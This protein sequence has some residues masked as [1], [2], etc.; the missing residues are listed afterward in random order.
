MTTSVAQEYQLQEL[1][2][3]T[4]KQL[5][6]TCVRLESRREMMQILLEELHNERAKLQRHQ[7]MVSD[8]ITKVEGPAGSANVAR[9]IQNFKVRATSQVATSTEVHAEMLGGPGNLQDTKHCGLFDAPA[10][11]VA[12]GTSSG[13]AA[14]RGRSPDCSVPNAVIS[15]IDTT[16]DSVNGMPL[17]SEVP[18]GLGFHV[19]AP[20]ELLARQAPSGVVTLT[21]FYNEEL[22][23]RFADPHDAIRNLTFEIRQL[24]EGANGRLRSRNHVCPCRGLAEGQEVGEQSF[25]VEGLAFGRPY[26]FTVRACLKVDGYVAPIYSAPSETIAVGSV[27]FQNLDIATATCTPR[28]AVHMA[29]VASGVGA[30]SASQWSSADAHLRPEDEDAHRREQKARQQQ[31]STWRRREVQED[32]TMHDSG[33][34]EKMLEEEVLRRL[35]EERRRIT[36]EAQRAAENERWRLEEELKQRRQ[37]EQ[38][39]IREHEE[40]RQRFVDEMRSMEYESRRQLEEEA[41]QSIRNQ[42]R[43]L[44]EEEAR[45]HAADIARREE[46]LARHR[47]AEALRRLAEEARER[48]AEAKRR[49]DNEYATQRQS[50]EQMRQEEEQMRQEEEAL[51]KRVEDQIRKRVDVEARR[52]DNE[53]ARRREEEQ[54]Q[55]QDEE[56]DQEEHG[57]QCQDGQNSDQATISLGSPAGPSRVTSS[58][59]GR[60]RG[61]GLNARRGTAGDAATS[62]AQGFTQYCK[63]KAAG[64]TGPQSGTRKTVPPQ[65]K[66][67]APYH[68]PSAASSLTGSRKA[69]ATGTPGSSGETRSTPGRDTAV[70]TQNGAQVV[71]VEVTVQ[72]GSADP[73]DKWMSK[74]LTEKNMPP[75]T[76]APNPIEAQRTPPAS[77]GTAQPQPKERSEAAPRVKTRASMPGTIPHP[78]ED[79]E[80]LSRSPQPSAARH[81]GKSGGV[82][83]R[84]SHAPSRSPDGMAT[85]MQ[86]PKR[87]SPAVAADRG[88]QPELRPPPQAEP[89]RVQSL[90]PTIGEST[91][92]VNACQIAD[93]AGMNIGDS[94]RHLGKDLIGGSMRFQ[95]SGA[96]DGSIMP[97][98]M[99]I[100]R[101]QTFATGKTG[102]GVVPC[103]TTTLT[104][105]LGGGVQ[106]RSSSFSTYPSV[107]GSK[108]PSPCVG[109]GS[110]AVRR[111]SPMR[112]SQG[113]GALQQQ[114]RQPVQ[115]RPP[116]GPQPQQQGFN[117]ASTDS[118]KSPCVAAPSARQSQ[119]PSRVPSQQGPPLAAVQPPQQ[120]FNQVGLT[121][122]NLEISQRLARANDLQQRLVNNAPQPAFAAKMPPGITME[123][124]NLLDWYKEQ[125]NRARSLDEPRAPTID[126]PHG[127]FG[128]QTLHN[129]PP[130]PRSAP[131]AEEAAACFGRIH[132][133]D[134]APDR[135]SLSFT[136]TVLTSDSRWENLIFSATENLEAVG[137]TFLQ[138][139]G[140]KT[141]FRAGLVSKM[142]S[143]ITSGQ[144]NSSVD[145]VDLI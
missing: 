49:L 30:T 123:M 98:N 55:P 9:L 20:E 99:Q 38:K 129:L 133:V 41:L 114:A 50:E 14:L 13:G 138:E 1:S 94:T 64:S 72:S 45:R 96:Q 106:A 137:T 32:G 47:E 80:R 79:S 63:G 128:L 28:D 23:E 89:L 7:T 117:P 6:E 102:V 65:A 2:Y 118:C 90:G 71:N 48:E 140:L 3:M 36:D 59:P 101:S 69:A 70:S 4:H 86:L 37:D 22:L 56:E 107:P 66:S 29:A 26:A 61:R 51:Q 57:Q 40:A 113:P 82:T 15:E 110:G 103:N 120:G 46:E 141:A 84:A 95:Q 135:S 77:G 24:S 122:A 81:G 75:V 91:R 73:M 42:E 121:G 87:A 76:L 97:G 92:H 74:I 130:P 19:C 104:V 33:A 12:E 78:K 62:F 88:R 67:S 136:L 93:P 5:V 27:G 116:T 52:R 112:P 124:P 8:R 16:C 43:S 143:M 34:T 144:T 100:P 83:G 25:E 111:F 127:P 10:S 60:G 11:T 85:V 39:Q 125:G 18:A 134:N 131:A 53:E 35:S 142:Q 105:G 132:G 31:E 126:D 17:S 145:I 54:S 109:P 58:A 68:A 44:Q 115:Q 119:V 108:S 139:K 21:W